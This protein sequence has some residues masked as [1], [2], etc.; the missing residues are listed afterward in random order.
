MKYYN[1]MCKSPIEIKVIDN[2]K[3]KKIVTE[4]PYVSVYDDLYIV[5][6]KSNRQL[7]LFRKE[8]T[9]YVKDKRKWKKI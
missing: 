5:I 7:T 1:I 8:F 3:N 4:V 2:E 9:I 6:T